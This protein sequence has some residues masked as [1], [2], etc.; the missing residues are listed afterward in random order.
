MEFG[1]YFRGFT[2]DFKDFK[3]DFRDFWSDFT[4]YRDL[5][6]CR[7]FRDLGSDFRTFCT[8]NFRSIVCPSDQ[9]LE[10]DQYSIF[11]V[12]SHFF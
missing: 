9:C 3:P 8:L 12:I 7:D 10:N 4:D 11:K 6:G 2:S 5:R 1:P